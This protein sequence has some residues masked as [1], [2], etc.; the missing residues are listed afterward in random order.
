[1]LSKYHR[2][3]SKI[4]SFFFFSVLYFW[5]NNKSENKIRAWGMGLLLLVFF[6]LALMAKIFEW[7]KWQ[8]IQFDLIKYLNG[9]LCYCK[10][11][12]WK[13]YFWILIA[14]LHCNIYKIIKQYGN[15]IFLKNIFWSNT[16]NFEKIKKK[17]LNSELNSFFKLK[18]DE[19]ANTVWYLISKNEKPKLINEMVVFKREKLKK[20]KRERWREKKI[21]KHSSSFEI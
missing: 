5:L 10:L 4:V 6:Q 21:K 3:I 8:F 19:I 18:L 17:S 13:I 12:I 2:E 15:K 14:G 16:R 9:L 20:E 11:R 1:M 7:W